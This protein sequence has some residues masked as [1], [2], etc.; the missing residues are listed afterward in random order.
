MRNFKIKIERKSIMTEK[1]IPTVNSKDTKATILSAYNAAINKLNEYQSTSLNPKMKMS[2][3]KKQE[4][5]QK[6]G[7]LNNLQ[8]FIN[9][10][11]KFI[12]ETLD[13]YNTVNDAIKYKKDE[14]K[15]LFDIESE[16]LTLAALID[17]NK[18]LKR[19]FNEESEIERENLNSVH[20]RIRNEISELKNNAQKERKREDEEWKYEFERKKKADIDALS[21]QLNAD[22]KM[23][24]I[25]ILTRYDELDSKYKELKAREDEISNSEDELV[26]LKEKVANM[27]IV[28]AEEVKA[29]V[30]KAQGMLVNKYEQEKK[31]FERDVAAKLE[32]VESKNVSL[33][34]ENTTL[35]SQIDILNEKLEHA[36]REIK[37]ISIKTVEGAGNSQ[38][39]A[40]MKTLLKDRG[41]TK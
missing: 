33:E 28:I 5:I 4:T 19:K 3:Q 32:L 15:N 36:Y 18:E 16:C 10:A 17:S 13:E 6:A 1:D 25:R 34:Q 12:E 38:M 7:D 24:D 29:K 26:E 40:E 2:E 20:E 35:K 30:G 27:P 23:H 31:F 37:E 41:N 14:L 8:D 11:S 21:D 9:D 39:F 22:K